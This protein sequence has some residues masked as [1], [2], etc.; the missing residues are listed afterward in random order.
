MDQNWSNVH[1]LMTLIVTASRVH[2]SQGY[3]QPYTFS[4]GLTIKTLLSVVIDTDRSRTARG[5][6]VGWSFISTTAVLDAAAYRDWS[7]TSGLA[8]NLSPWT[9]AFSF[10]PASVAVSVFTRSSNHCFPNCCSS[11][12]RV[13]DSRSPFKL[14]RSDLRGQTTG[15]GFFPCWTRC[16]GSKVK[17]DQPFFLQ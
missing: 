8:E 13:P 1:C 10:P 7:F 17:L 9:C 15:E 12:W 11:N 5:L 14:P 3:C 4:V 6:S 2:R 16:F